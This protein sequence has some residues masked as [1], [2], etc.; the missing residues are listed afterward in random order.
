MVIRR[1]RDDKLRGK[2]GQAGA[3][4]RSLA[5]GAGGRQVGGS[6][7]GCLKIIALWATSVSVAG[8]VVP[9]AHPVAAD[10]VRVINHTRTSSDAESGR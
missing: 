7:R 6:S 2:A 10:D 3:V 4:N 5:G 9:V 1:I 8:A